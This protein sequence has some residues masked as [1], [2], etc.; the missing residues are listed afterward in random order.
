MKEEEKTNREKIN[1]KHR[2]QVKREK[3]MY[4]KDG[5]SFHRWKLYIPL[6]TF[7]NTFNP[8]LLCNFHL[9]STFVI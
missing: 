5:E 9:L 2:F 7:S 4:K 6:S 3:Y 1:S 8:L